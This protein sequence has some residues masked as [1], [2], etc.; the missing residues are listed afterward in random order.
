MVRRHADRL[1]WIAILAALA[2]RQPMGSKAA[3]F[4]DEIEALAQG[5]KPRNR[6]RDRLTILTAFSAAEVIS[7][8]ARCDW[9]AAAS[10]MV[11]G[12]RRGAALA[13][14]PEL[15]TEEATAV[16]VPRRHQ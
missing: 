16:A 15:T 14:L 7:G 10:A 5:R 2:Q 11:A 8:V 3:A 4:L 6:E 13:A 1:R 12:L 9:E